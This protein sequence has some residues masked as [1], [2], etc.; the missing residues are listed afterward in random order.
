MAALLTFYFHSYWD[1]VGG[2]ITDAVLEN[3]ANGATI[4]VRLQHS[5]SRC[6]CELRSEV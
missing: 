2:D 6:L 1:H 3:A 4:I 5:S